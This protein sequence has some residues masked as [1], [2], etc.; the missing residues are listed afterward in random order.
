M[1]L[2][3]EEFERIA[4][5]L[6]G[7]LSGTE[8]DA[9]DQWRNSSPKNESDF[10][11]AA[12]IWARSG[13]KFST[14]SDT[15]ADWNR[16]D[17]AIRLQSDKKGKVVGMY[18]N[19]FLRIAASMLLLATAGYIIYLL[20]YSRPTA[21]AAVDEVV[22]VWLPDSSR[23]WLNQSSSLRYDEGFGTKHRNLTLKGEGYFAVKRME[24]LPFVV[25]TERTS[26]RVLGTSFNLKEDSTTV[27]LTVAEG[28]VAFSP[29]SA[30]KPVL[31]ERGETSVANG[32]AVTKSRTKNKDFAQWRTRNNP[33]FERE[34]SAAA[35]FLSTT[36]TWNKNQI[37][38]SVIR[39]TIFNSASNA[40]Y[41]NIVIIATY[42]KPNGT[43]GKAR[44][45]ISDTVDP[46]KRISFERRLLD[47][48]TDTRDLR[49][50]VESAQAIIR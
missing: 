9:V 20:A 36:H 1:A 12:K 25:A 40:S 7:N 49:L 39:G 16:L 18:S 11:E 50:D 47:I 15:D 4:A 41:K 22:T 29:K 6:S 43:T 32:N 35:Q 46:G 21:V 8:A 23:V 14:G 48:F 10:Q 13:L 28:K 26:T 27:S 33:T 45:T 2:K 5:Y 17:T 34:S 19:P 3:P 37:N 44:L 30:Q 42:R 31:V 38:Q 24:R